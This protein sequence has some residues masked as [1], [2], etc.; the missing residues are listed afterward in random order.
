M[1]CATINVAC[2]GGQATPFPFRLLENTRKCFGRGVQGGSGFSEFLE[3]VCARRHPTRSVC[4][5]YNDK[6]EWG[7]TGETKVIPVAY[8]VPENVAAV[9][10]LYVAGI[11]L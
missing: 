2:V 11:V 5:V 4:M 9:A 10:R 8:Q 1:S 7:H 3:T 6:Q